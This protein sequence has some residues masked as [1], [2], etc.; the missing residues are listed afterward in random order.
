MVDKG[1]DKGIKDEKGK[2]AC[3]LGKCFKRNI[4]HY[5]YFKAVDRELK[6]LLEVEKEDEAYDSNDE[7]CQKTHE[8]NYKK[9]GTI[10]RGELMKSRRFEKRNDN[11]YFND[12]PS[13]M[14]RESRRIFKVKTRIS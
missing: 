8:E 3:D 13:S 7:D 9:Y 1:V 10:L 4:P 2:L 5:L 6:K 12:V 14:A 11:P